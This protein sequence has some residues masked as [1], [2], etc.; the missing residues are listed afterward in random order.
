MG[1]ARGAGGAAAGPAMHESGRGRWIGLAM[2]S[3]GVAM[4]IVDAT[5][6]NVAVPSIIRDL[7]LDSTAAEWVNAI[8]TLVFA[9]LLVT[10]GRMGDVL[11]RRAMYLVGLVLFMAASM[12]AGVANSG[13]MLI[14]ARLAQGLG[15]AMI[16]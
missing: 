4:I 2:L 3:L 8:Y 13:E 10:L 1:Q 12:V 14:G 6:V 5:I 9:A 16:L 15:G 7:K 11:G